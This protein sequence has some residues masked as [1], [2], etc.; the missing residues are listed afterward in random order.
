MHSTDR[1]TVCVPEESVNHNEGEEF[2]R[3][4]VVVGSYKVPQTPTFHRLHAPTTSKV[5]IADASN[6]ETHETANVHESKTGGKHVRKH[7]L[8]SV[9]MRMHVGLQV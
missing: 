6:D 3:D 8:R 7:A 2:F 1:S 5:E 9:L 4:A